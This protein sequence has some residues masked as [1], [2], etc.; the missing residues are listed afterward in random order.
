MSHI[1]YIANQ[2]PAAVEPYV[3]EEVQELR[4]R[5]HTIRC[6]SVHSPK[7]ERET[8]RFAEE[9]V[10]L[11]PIRLALILPAT[12]LLLWNVATLRDCL[13]RILARGDESIFVRARA[14][15]HTWLGAYYAVLLKGKG[16]EHLHAHHGYSASWVAMVAARILRTGFSLTLH[17]SDLLIHH[18]Y[19]DT[20]LA[21][22][23]F[24]LT[25]SEFNRNH[26]VRCYPNV[27]ADKI[28]VQRLGVETSMTDAPSFPRDD[29][30]IL[31]I[32][33]VGRLHRV[34]NH[35]FLIQGCR[36][37]KSLGLR[38]FCII[39]GEGPEHITLERLI[40]K[41]DLEE[42]VK[43]FGQVPRQRLDSYYSICDLVVLTS[44]SEG[45]PLVL[46]EAMAHGRTVLA[47]EITG[48][49]ELVIPGKTGFLY[50]PDSLEDFVAK[51]KTVSLARNA[52]AP[53]RRAA[54]RHVV[55][56]FNRSTNLS[57]FA[58]LF[59]S[60]IY[61]STP[62]KPAHENSLLQQIQL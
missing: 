50:A 3:W 40:R 5:G 59:L 47:P 45:L 7:L 42:E 49:P 12:M 11:F 18:S 53:M 20:K 38:F 16:V 29:E 43:L 60:R 8:Q 35:E 1:A 34:K 56:Y 25:V 14:L 21:N 10:G 46:M 57:A 24:C 26:I 55:Q 52:L 9:T 22:C 37:L 23:T 17:G 19:L 39:V 27:N 32:L 58:E 30:S 51:V 61:S 13:R 41:L 31:L 62:E 44:R 54:R 33:S 15:L 28:I 36:E 4:R 48:I 6:Y 2:F